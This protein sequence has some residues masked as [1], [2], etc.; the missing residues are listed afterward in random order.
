VYHRRRRPRALDLPSTLIQ[1]VPKSVEL[2][3]RIARVEQNLQAVMRRL[4]ALEA[5][6][7]HLTAIDRHN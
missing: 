3:Q 1:N 7:D 5:Q 6:L 4:R 2:E